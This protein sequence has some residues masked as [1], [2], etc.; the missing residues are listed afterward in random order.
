VS[1]TYRHESVAYGEYA[2]AGRGRRRRRDDAPPSAPKIVAPRPPRAASRSWR[3]LIRRIYEV[4]PLVCPCGGT[5]RVIA[6]LT[7]RAVVERILRH[8]GLWPP[9]AAA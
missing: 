7:E 3:E 6:F 4:D 9:P 1:D 5:L 8:L 2:N